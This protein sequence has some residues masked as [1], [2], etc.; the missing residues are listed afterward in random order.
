MTGGWILFRENPNLTR[1]GS[2]ESNLPRVGTTPDGRLVSDAHK[3][4]EGYSQHDCE[5]DRQHLAM[6]DDFQ[7]FHD[8]FDVA[9]RSNVTFYPV[10]ALGLVAFDKGIG[11]ETVEG[12]IQ[13]LG[14]AA[15]VGQDPNMLVNP[16][17]AD[18][19]MISQ[20]SDNLR[21]L[22]ENTDGLAVVDTNDLDKGMK[23]IVDDLTSY[24]LLGYTSTNGKLDGRYRKISVRVKRPGVDVRARRGY[25]AATEKEVEEGRIAQ[26]KQ[27]DSAPPTTMQ[28]ALNAL[29]TARPGIPLHTS[30]SYATLGGSTAITKA[31]VW[32]LVELDSAV[33]RQ[34]DWMAGG[35]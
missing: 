31:H 18:R 19:A 29:A 30:V 14:P 28:V 22:A 27:I 32:A 7:F 34:S 8:M 26:V 4:T 35:G 24:Y 1:G 20:R 16:L 23:R 9:N 33:L 17:V 15:H 25:R 10:N 21:A 2:G 13:A 11:E 6:L 5:I 3:Y 12:E